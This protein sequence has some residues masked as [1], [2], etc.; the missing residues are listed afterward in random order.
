MNWVAALWAGSTENTSLPDAP[1]VRL[2][3][4]IEVALSSSSEPL[5]RLMATPLD[6]PVAR[7]LPA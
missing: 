6:E 4:F 5:L 3:S 1:T 2:V 7:R